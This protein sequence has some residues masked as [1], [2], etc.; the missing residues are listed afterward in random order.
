MK[1]YQ[2]EF[3]RASVFKSVIFLLPVCGYRG[4]NVPMDTISMFFWP[5]IVDL[6]R[7]DIFEK[8]TGGIYY[9]GV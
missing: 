6:T 1:H 2:G 3:Y 9:H 5:V 8:C 4:I 7:N